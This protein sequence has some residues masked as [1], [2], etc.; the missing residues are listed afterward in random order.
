MRLEDHISYDDPIDEFKTYTVEFDTVVVVDE[1]GVM[2][3][4]E[5]T[6]E[7]EDLQDDEYNIDVDSG[8]EVADKI[9]DLA[10]NNIPDEAGEYRISGIAK[11]KYEIGPIYSGYSEPDRRDESGNYFYDA[12][13]AEATYMKRSS[14]IENFQCEAE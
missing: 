14:W 10:S 2:T 1:D 8:F 3:P 4:K 12:S 13:E 5:G 9:L 7:T 11:L 6:W